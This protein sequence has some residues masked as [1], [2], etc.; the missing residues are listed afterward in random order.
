MEAYFPTELS[1][2]VIR[3]MRFREWSNQDHKTNQ[4]KISLVVPEY[5]FLFKSNINPPVPKAPFVDLGYFRDREQNQ[6][7]EIIIE[8]GVI[9]HE[10][11]LSDYYNY[12]AQKSGEEV[13]QQRFIDDDTDKPDMLLSKKFPD[14]QTWITRRTGYK[15]WMGENGA[16][17]VTLNMACNQNYYYQNADMFYYILSTFRP[18]YPPEYQLAERLKLH[19]KRFPVDFATY[20]PISWTEVHHHN[21][22]MEEM[23]SGLTKIYKEQLS[24]VLTVNAASMRKYPTAETILWPY[25]SAY[26]DKGF[27]FNTISTREANVFGRFHTVADSINFTYR[28][29]GQ[30]MDYNLTFYLGNDSNNWFYVEMFGLAKTQ[31]FEAWAINKRALQLLIQNFK[32]V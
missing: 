20:V 28:Q 27:D 11:S 16:F 22:T 30:A 23:K 9:Q 26:F 2:E 14:G 32:T 24:G 18:V 17:V 5:L 3:S 4:L 19:T 25:L 21:D 31:D 13:L 7:L 29:A 12:M 10:I 15:V 6:M 1:P 8:A